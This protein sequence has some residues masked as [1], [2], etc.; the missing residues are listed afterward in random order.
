[1]INSEQYSIIFPARIVTYDAATQTAE[2]LV[3]AERITNNSN[4]S[5]VIEKRKSIKGVPV[6]TPSGGGWALTF[7]IKPGE[8]CLIMFSQVG[9]DHWFYEDKDEAGEFASLPQPWLMRQFNED[10]GFAFVGLNNLKRTV[11]SYDAANSQWRGVDPTKQVISLNDDTSIEI[12]SN[13]SVTI[14]APSVEVN[15]AT[16][17]VNA[18]AS[19]DVVTPVV[20]ID[21]PVTNM[22]GVLNVSGVTTT[23]G[24]VVAGGAAANMGSGSLTH[25]GP[26]TSSGS[27]AVNGINLETH[28]HTIGSGSSAGE[29]STPN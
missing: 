29:T 24:I 6:H 19:V 28:T 15:C 7:P 20:T 5:N 12:T 27:I 13:I 11:P 16:A 8:P 21:A 10:D 9:Y 22:T 3:C 4:K 2:I 1:M 18:T 23:G 14:N 17:A 26:M 25:S